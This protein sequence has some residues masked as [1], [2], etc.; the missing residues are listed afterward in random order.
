M[1]LKVFDTM[2]ILTASIVYVATAPQIAPASVSGSGGEGGAG[3]EGGLIGELDLEEVVAGNA[4][5]MITN[6][7]ADGNMTAGGT[8]ST[9]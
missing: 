1:N 8:N 6:Q 4:T 3:G 5:T 2:L 7:T 9:S